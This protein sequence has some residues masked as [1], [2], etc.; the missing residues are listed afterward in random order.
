MVYRAKVG[1]RAVELV[2]SSFAVMHYLMG[3][4]VYG[5]TAALEALGVSPSTVTQ[6]GFLYRTS[7]LG[8]ES[9]LITSYM[10]CQSCPMRIVK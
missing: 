3:S 9:I 6:G 1:K 8:Q 2:E 10:L 4:L 5:L 7:G